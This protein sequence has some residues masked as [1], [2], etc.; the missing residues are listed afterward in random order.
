MRHKITDNMTSRLSALSQE[1]METLL[2]DNESDDELET[3]ELSGSDKMMITLYIHQMRSVTVN[4]VKKNLLDLFAERQQSVHVD[5][6][7]NGGVPP[8]APV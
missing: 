7:Q 4:Q 1:E 2:H 5:C 6:P 3:V 8:T